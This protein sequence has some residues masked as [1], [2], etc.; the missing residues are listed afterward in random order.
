MFQKTIFLGL[1]D[2]YAD[3]FSH[4]EDDGDLVINL[5]DNVKKRIFER[6]WQEFIDLAWLIG[7]KNTKV[8]VELRYKSKSASDIGDYYLTG[9]IISLKNELFVDSYTS[10]F[11]DTNQM[12]SMSVRRNTLDSNDDLIVDYKLNNHL[13][14]QVR[15]FW[16]LEPLSDIER[17]DCILKEVEN[18]FISHTNNRAYYQI[19]LA[20]PIYKIKRLRFYSIYEE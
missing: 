19:G 18:E 3:V 13:E 17:F 12:Q 15:I 16:S 7:L 1:L 4:K 10:I 20:I 14:D 2:Q 5:K 9:K 8:N 11:M 6:F